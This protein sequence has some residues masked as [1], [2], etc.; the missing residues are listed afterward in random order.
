MRESQ[1]DELCGLEQTAVSWA[2][3]KEEIISA[4]TQKD[5]PVLEKHASEQSCFIFPLNAYNFQV[6][7]KKLLTPQPKHIIWQFF[8][9]IYH[10][11]THILGYPQKAKQTQILCKYC[12]A[13]QDLHIQSGS[14]S[15]KKVS[16]FYSNGIM[17][18]NCTNTHLRSPHS[19]SDVSLV[20]VTYI[21]RKQVNSKITAGRKCHS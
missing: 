10:S 11:K 1:F 3:W 21:Y 18:I 5:L 13:T 8:Q 7:C 20:Q 16:H 17:W 4:F 2:I 14:D 15:E 19:Q 12:Y 6:Y 9:Y